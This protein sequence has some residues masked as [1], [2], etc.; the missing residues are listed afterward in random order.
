MP[1]IY[2]SIDAETGEEIIIFIRRGKEVGMYRDAI[3]KRFIR[4]FNGFTIQVALL[5]SY[6]MSGAKHKNPLYVDVK[7]ATFVGVD[8]VKNIEDIEK[9][10]GR[11]AKDVIQQNFGEYVSDLAEIVGVE[12]KVEITEEV[13]PDYHWYLVWHHYKRDEREKDGV[14]TIGQV[15]SGKS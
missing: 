9:E 11:E 10:L 6:P 4:G 5:F 14:D 13:Y 2:R 15:P 7:L 8:E 3:T 1:I 12:H